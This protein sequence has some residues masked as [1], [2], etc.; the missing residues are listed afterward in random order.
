MQGNSKK[1]ENGLK[2]ANVLDLK[3]EWCQTRTNSLWQRL[4]YS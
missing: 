1:V 3:R 4:R 2:E